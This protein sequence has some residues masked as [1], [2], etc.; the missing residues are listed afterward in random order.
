MP[1]KEIEL[2]ITCVLE[3][4]IGIYQILVCFHPFLIRRRLIKCGT[5][6]STNCLEVSYTVQLFNNQYFTV[7]VQHSQS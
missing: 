7:M 6:N 2:K 3:L 4:K 5:V 1:Y